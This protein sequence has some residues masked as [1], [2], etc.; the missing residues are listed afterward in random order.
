MHPALRYL[1]FR[2]S[3]GGLKHRLSRLKNPRYFVPALLAIAYFWLSFG[4]P[5]LA[6]SRAGDDG[7]DTF[8]RLRVFIGPGLGLMLAMGW[9]VA[10]SRPAPAFT[11]PEASQLF[12]LPFTRRELVNYRLLRPQLIFLLIGG[13]AALGSLR[14]PQLN[15][16]FAGAGG[17]LLMNLLSLNTMAAALAS[18]RMKNAG[19]PK[20]LLYLPSLLLIGWVLGPLLYNY[21][22]ME[23]G[24]E[25]WREWLLN[26]MQGGSAAWAHWPLQQLA[27]MIGASDLAQFGRGAASVLV[28]CAALWALCMLLVAPFEER[29]LELAETTGRK[30]EAMRRGGAFA[31][32]AGSLKKTRSTRLKLN[33]T[34]PT[35]R[36]VFWQTLVAEWRIGMW[37]LAIG[38]AGILLAL[39]VFGE[40]FTKSRG[41][42][43][44]AIG[45]S[46]AMGS[47]LLMMGPRMMATGLHA[48]LRRLP[49]WKGLPITGYSLLRGKVW[50]GALLVT[51]AALLMMTAA[52]IASLT[53]SKWNQAPVIMGV[54]AGL[55]PLVP[56]AA[57]M[58]IGLESAAVLMLP[59]WLS[60]TH[61]EPGFETIGRNLLSLMVRMVLGS[62]LAIIPGG[63]FAIAAAIG[64]ALKL[65]A[66]GF[67]I[68]GVIAAVALAAEME[69]LLLL[70]GRRFDEMDSTPE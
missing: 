37:K 4:M 16:L 52:V 8:E 12:V 48:E 31:A 21:Q 24:D 19:W 13:F 45:L 38:V 1:A 42:A 11:R 39:A 46:A 26:L 3:A 9:A 69:G 10:T 44:F 40:H 32:A 33:A 34:G 43:V 30:I 35:S 64:L 14:S 66:P 51:P 22:V 5:G 49:L 57:M 61:S 41:V 58:M 47:M 7:H 29:A 23:A 56:V 67:A 17:F 53:L 15:P 60:S 62:L 65:P 54:Y 36:A 25:G 18:N 28:A 68:G 59:A 55:I 2:Q 27:L 63:L 70:V 50:A 6:P 20:P